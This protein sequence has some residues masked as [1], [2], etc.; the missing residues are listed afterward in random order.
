MNSPDTVDV[1]HGQGAP[2]TPVPLHRR[3]P[4]AL[5]IT[6]LVVLGGLV[7]PSALATP[8]G[9]V[10]ADV[11]L[12]VGWGYVL[13]APVTT[14]LDTLSV[15]TLGQH[16]AFLATL[17]AVFV[18]WRLVRRR[19]RRGWLRRVGIELGVAAVSLLGL[20]AFYG[21]GVIA[22][23]PMAGI[24]P[25]HVDDVVVDVHSHTAYSHDAWQA[26]GVEDRRAWHAAAGFDAA[27]VSDHRNW[28]GWLDAVPNN[29][30]RAGD[31]TS[32]LPALE[33]A[34]I[35]WY[36]NALGPPERYEGAVDGNHLIVDSM[37]AR[38]DRGAPRPTLVLTIPEDLEGAP[39][40]TEDSIGFVAIEVSD[41]SPKGLRQSRR[42]RE[43]ILAMVD[44]LDLAPVAATNNHGWG[45]TAAAWTLM[46]I[47][48]WEALTPEQLNVAIEDR[49]HRERKDASRVIERRSPWLGESVPALALT[50][51]AITWQ[52]F[53]GLGFASRVSW[54]AWTWAAAL[55]LA[56]IRRRRADGS[57]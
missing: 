33:I 26:F 44:S 12:D 17:I 54:L 35:E 45:R 34:W 10:P 8:T 13:M 36:A 42:D 3:H 7:G 53:G 21:Y 15:L 18:V 30:E 2:E 51:P 47:P 38:L 11:R 50:A 22:P 57:Q 23:R 56:G 48:G 27:Y 43:L 25:E 20:L 19:E 4:V 1:A 16:Y 32:L 55:L 31:G 28:L 9:G 29:P 49:L 39:A 6:L 5:V 46:R 41:A 24:E 52:L 37:Y 14:V 40:S